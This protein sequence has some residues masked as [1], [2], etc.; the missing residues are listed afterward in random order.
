MVETSL[1]GISIKRVLQSYTL[2][3][4]QRT[5]DAYAEL[6]DTARKQVDEAIAG[7]GWE[8]VLAYEPRHRLEKDGYKLVFV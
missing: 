4:L 5:L 8:P 2:W 7:T 1:R 6:A 3:M